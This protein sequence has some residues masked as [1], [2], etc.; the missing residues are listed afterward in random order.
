MNLVVRDLRYDQALFAPL[1]AEGLQGDGRFLARLRDE[2]LSGA[3]RFDR[4]G[5]CLLGAFGG[6]AL[7]GVGGVSLDPY[8]PAPDLGRVRHVYVLRAYRRRGIG[9]ALMET[10]LERAGRDFAVLRLRTE[11]PEAV[12]LYES[13]GF[14][15]TDAAGETHRLVL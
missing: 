14:V 15:G 11:R 9:R 5:E 7:V 10:V 8:H 1:I 13:F 2:W 12:R 6:D 4:P 3:T